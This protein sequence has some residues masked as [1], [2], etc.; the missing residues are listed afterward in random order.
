MRPLPQICRAPDYILPASLQMLGDT[1]VIEG[2]H[3]PLQKIKNV[4]ECAYAALKPGGIILII[5][6]ESQ[7][8]AWSYALENRG[9]DIKDCLCIATKQDIVSLVIVAMKAGEK[10]YFENALKHQVAGFWIDGNRIGDK[11]SGWNGLTAKGNTWNA[12]NCG[13]R[14][15]GQAT[16]TRGKFPSNFILA[17]PHHV[18]QDFFHILTSANDLLVFLCK[19]TKTP[20]SGLVIH[21]PALTPPLYQATIK[22][23][24]QYLGIVEHEEQAQK[25]EGLWHGND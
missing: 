2:N 13:L 1:V 15:T 10:T 24:R 14:K 5:V 8:L 22:S 20:H 25:L 23:G 16:L 11:V 19:L 6:T 18:L 4:I 9:L 3:V 17:E 21:I 12:Q 7:S